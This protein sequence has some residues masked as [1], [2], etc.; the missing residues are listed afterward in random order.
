MNSDETRQ[1][2]QHMRE[3]AKELADAAERTD[4]PQ[5]RARLQ[6]KSRS[7]RSRCEQESGMRSG[8]IYPW[9]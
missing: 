9:Q 6:E 2:L 4:D 3:K 7:L 1:R 8:D 5:Q